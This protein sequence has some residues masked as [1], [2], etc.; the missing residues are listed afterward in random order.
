[1]SA[2]TTSS[3]DVSISTKGIS[4]TDVAAEKVLALLSEGRDDLSL[5]VA[6]QPVVAL[7]FAT[8]FILMTVN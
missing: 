4:L 3:T 8:N 1:M 2:E 7:V 5:R 6:V